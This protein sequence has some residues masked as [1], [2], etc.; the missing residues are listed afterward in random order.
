MLTNK[1]KESA[2]KLL[3]K[4]ILILLPVFTQ[5]QI[6]IDGNINELTNYRQIATANNNNGFNN[7]NDLGAL[8]YFSDATNL[9]LGITGTVEDNTNN[10]IVLFID[11]VS[12]DGRNG[13]LGNAT[14]GNGVGVGVFQYSATCL[15]PSKLDAG[16]DADYAFAFNKGNTNTNMYFDAMR[17]GRNTG[18]E[19]FQYGNVGSCSLNGTSVTQTIPFCDPH[20]GCTPSGTVTY[21][22]QNGFVAAPSP[23]QQYGIEL[24][25]PL[26]FLPGVQTGHRVRFFVLITNGVGFGSNE[27]MP[28]DPINNL[29]CNFDLSTISNPGNDVFYTIPDVVLTLNF[30]STTAKL[31]NNMAIIEWSVM[32]DVEALSFSIERSYNS[33]TY[34][35][36]GSVPA[37]NKKDIASYSFSDKMPQAGK[38]YYRIKAILRNGTAKYSSISAVENNKGTFFVYPN[39]AEGRE[40]SISTGGMATGSYQLTVRNT[41]GQ[42]VFTIP[43]V[44]AAPVAT[45]KVALPQHLPAGTYYVQ[46]QAGKSSYNQTVLLL[47]N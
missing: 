4:F 9:Y 47:G 8:Y 19:Y 16:F 20:P 29:G 6:V 27:C 28:G 10:N 21:A 12:Y 43:I 22:F 42:Q 36:V 32:Q 30:L 2:M 17:F 5:S 31:Q 33:T 38:N 18:D 34:T 24:A 13:I 15:G 26:S 25:I 23:T 37:Q 3:A 40:F 41:S 46:L 7:G 14:Y 11:D 35:T 1:T 45:H 44:H 39:P